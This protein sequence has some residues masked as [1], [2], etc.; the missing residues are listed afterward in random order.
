MPLASVS[1]ITQ[2]KKDTELFLSK[3][4]LLA[5]SFKLPSQTLNQFKIYFETI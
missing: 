2:A 4:V 3:I 1:N 5:V